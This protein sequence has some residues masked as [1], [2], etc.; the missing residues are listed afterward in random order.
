MPPYTAFLLEPG[1]QRNPTRLVQE[2]LKDFLFRGSS[3]REARSAVGAP[4]EHREGTKGRG[5]AAGPVRT[6]A[7]GDINRQDLLL[8]GLQRLAE[9]CPSRRKKYPGFSFLPPSASCWFFPL[10]RPNQQPPAGN[11]RAEGTAVSFLDTEQDGKEKNGPRKDS[12][13]HEPYI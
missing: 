6:A 1:R 7:E 11:S 2:T 10:T 5:G 3:T 13:L 8:W 12:R 4:E 9:I